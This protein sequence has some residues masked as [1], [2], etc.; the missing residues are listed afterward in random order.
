MNNVPHLSERIPA[1]AHDRAAWTEAERRHLADCEACAAEWE[2]VR[3]AVGLG[4]EVERTLASGP[5]VEGVLAGLRRPEVRRRPPAGRLVWAAAAAAAAAILVLVFRSG[6]APE[7]GQLSVLPEIAS[8][9]TEELQALLDILP[10][11]NG[12]SY[13]MQSFEDLTE[14]ELE[15]I[16]RSMEG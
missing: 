14:E 1:V 8:M 10:A 3:T 7:S 6:P 16:L 15:G 11:G 9:E 13:H 2:L 4:L 12:W 5:I